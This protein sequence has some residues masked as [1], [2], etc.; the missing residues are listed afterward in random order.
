ML[1][2]GCHKSDPIDHVLAEAERET[3]HSYTYTPIA[4]PETAASEE[5][6]SNLF[7]RATLHG[8]TATPYTIQESRPLKNVPRYEHYKL[9]DLQT[10]VLLKTDTG[11]K[12]VLLRP[13]KTGWYYR[14]YSVR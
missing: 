9:L 6:I 5:V 11:Q 8:G 7:S 13:L 1:V 10:A 2:S 14:I 4:L 3:L 12:V